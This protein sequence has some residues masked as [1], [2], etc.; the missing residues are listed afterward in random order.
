VVKHLWN[1]AT[2]DDVGRQA[3]RKG[4]LKES[5]VKVIP[6]YLVKNTLVEGGVKAVVPVQGKY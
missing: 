4:T 6:K 2:V 3:G 5:T 1:F